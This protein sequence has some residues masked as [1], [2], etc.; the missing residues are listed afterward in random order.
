MDGDQGLAMFL[1]L[2]VGSGE[3]P[4]IWVLVGLPV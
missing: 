1:V 4:V 3:T 2:R